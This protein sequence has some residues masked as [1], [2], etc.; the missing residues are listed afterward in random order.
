VRKRPSRR[1]RH[2]NLDVVLFGSPSHPPSRQLI[3]A[4]FAHDTEGRKSQRELIEMG[5]GGVFGPE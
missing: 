2:Y 5:G 1:K 3:Q 4:R